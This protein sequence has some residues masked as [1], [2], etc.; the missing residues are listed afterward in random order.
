MIIQT[1]YEFG[2]IHGA[3]LCSNTPDSFAGKKYDFVML[4]SSWDQRC[5]E[6]TKRTDI[7]ANKVI[8]LD[9]IGRDQYGF[10][11]LHDEKLK[12]YIKVISPEPIILKEESVNLKQYWK[13]IFTCLSD[14]VKSAGRPINA[15]IDIS[16]SPKYYVLGVL[17]ALVK[18]GIC[19]GV[20][21]FYCE[22][23]Y[24]EN[25]KN[26]ISSSSKTFT[27]GKWDTVP[28]PF[29]KTVHD[30]TKR[31]Y[32]LVSVGFEG[33]KTMHIVRA[34]D[35]DRLS[36]LFP[37]PGITKEYVKRCKR[38]NSDLMESYNLPARQIIKTN[39]ADAILAWKMLT[40]ANLE[41]PENENIHYLCCGTSPHS[42]A[43]TLR[44]LT[45]GFATL[46]YR[47]PYGHSFLRVKP[48][49][50]YWQYSITDLAV[51]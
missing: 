4:S 23:L 10:R 32:Y 9:F 51:N 29:S 19:K 33:A 7:V 44:A 49:G 43:L 26:I 40:N 1:E 20:D 42:V 12:N 16:S 27:F 30:P 48:A 37:E 6:I 47:K 8:L 35:P 14:S 5:I 38:E 2:S 11:D 50:K 3:S 36:V 13:D 25:A 24:K 34:K 18:L 39:A 22:G 46:L 28:I 17:C 21:L 41:E 15:L 31:K 45:T